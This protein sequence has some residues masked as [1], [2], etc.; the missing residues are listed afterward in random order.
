MGGKII[1]EGGG[2][3]FSSI[4]ALEAL[5]GDMILCADVVEETA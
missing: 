1:S 4:I 3:K 2:E 5:D